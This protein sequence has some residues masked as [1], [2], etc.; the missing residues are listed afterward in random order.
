MNQTSSSTIILSRKSLKAEIWQ[1]LCNPQSNIKINMQHF[2]KYMKQLILFVNLKHSKDLNCKKRMSVPINSKWYDS[3][4]NCLWWFFKEIS[5]LFSDSEIYDV[6]HEM[7]YFLINLQDKNRLSISYDYRKHRTTRYFF[8]H[9]MK[10]KVIVTKE[11]NLCCLEL[12]SPYA[13]PYP[14]NKMYHSA[15][16]PSLGKSSGYAYDLA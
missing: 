12:S 14:A 10:K 7:T 16:Y 2:E 15:P 5:L 9:C 13:N 3:V 11:N 1:C 6:L 8:C 4:F